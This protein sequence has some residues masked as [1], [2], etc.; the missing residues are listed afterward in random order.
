MTK[1]E[2]LVLYKKALRDYKLLNS[3]WGR[4]FLHKWKY[5]VHHGFCA[6]FRY[7]HGVYINNLEFPELSIQSPLLNT[8]FCEGYWY[9]PGH[10]APRIKCLE[11]A[12]KLCKST[13]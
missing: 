2:K 3:L 8:T 5:Y 1:E 13:N 4:M 11:Q 7:R 9:K 12:I 6:Y 10:L